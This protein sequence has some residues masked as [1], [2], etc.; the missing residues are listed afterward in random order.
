M[1]PER[2]ASGTIPGHNCKICGEAETFVMCGRWQGM[3]CWTGS[4]IN[5][6]VL[7]NPLWEKGLG[8]TASWGVAFVVISVLFC[9]A[10]FGGYAEWIWQT[11][12]MCRMFLNLLVWSLCL[13][14]NVCAGRSFV[15]YLLS[16]SFCTGWLEWDSREGEAQRG[17]IVLFRQAGIKQSSSLWFSCMSES[18]TVPP[19]ALLLP[20]AV[21]RENFSLWTVQRDIFM[22][23][24]IA[25]ERTIWTY[26]IQDSGP[27]HLGTRVVMTSLK[28]DDMALNRVELRFQS[29][30]FTECKDKKMHK[31]MFIPFL[32]WSSKRDE[33]KEVKW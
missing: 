17:E 21:P 32:L 24:Y 1:A 2:T 8:H 12:F 6:S 23:Y 22:C 13:M 20:Y 18:C 14:K 5:C 10:L 29:F 19:G 27:I 26:S 11:G 15:P 7:P 30:K 31:E 28:V 25:S 9:L 16:P 4:K 3:Y 33:E